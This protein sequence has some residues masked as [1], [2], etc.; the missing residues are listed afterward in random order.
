M[1]PDTSE[2]TNRQTLMYLKAGSRALSLFHA[3]KQFTDI[4]QSRIFNECSFIFLTPH[5]IL[6]KLVCKF[7]E[8]RDG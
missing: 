8:D 6:S 5:D 3:S 1:K 2:M 7:L 4:L